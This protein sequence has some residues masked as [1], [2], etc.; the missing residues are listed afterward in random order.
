MRYVPC[1]SET[2][3]FAPGELAPE[4]VCIQYVDP[5]DG[6][7]KIVTV[8][9][10]AVATLRR[11]LTDPTVTLVLH[12]GAYDCA[13]WCRAGLTREV[14]AAFEAGR[15]LCTWVFER[16]GEVSGQTTRKQLDLA[17]CCKAHGI[18]LD[19]A[20]KQSGLG[21]EFGQ[22]RDALEIPEPHRS[23]ALGDVVVGKLFER[24]CKRFGRD[25]PLAAV[26]RLSYRQFCLQLL[27]VWGMQTD[28]DAVAALS[29]DAEAAL[30]ELRPLAQEWGFLRPNGTRNMAAIR[31]VVEESY[32]AACPRTATGLAQ[33]GEVVLEAADDP[34]LQAFSEY[35]SWLKTVSNDVPN[36]RASGT[37]WV[38]TRYGLAETLRTTSSGDKKGKRTGLIAMQNLRQAAGVRECIRPSAGH[39]FYNVDAKGL[40]L[41]TFADLCVSELGRRGM[42]DYI[43]QAGDPGIVHSRV[44]AMLA[45][46]SVETFQARLKAK[47]PLATTIRTRAKNGVFGYLG[48][49]G[50]K[51]YVEYIAKLSKGKVKL[52]V[53]EA[54][55]IR[56]AIFAAMPDIQAYLQW[57]GS[58]GLPDG[59]FDATLEYGITRRGIWY[60]AAANNRFQSR[61]AAAMGEVVI[62]L[63]KA[64]YIGGLSPARPCLFVHDELL[65][66]VPERDV[67]EFELAFLKLASAATQRIVRHVP[68][69]WDGEACDRYSK[70][71]KRVV[72]NGRLTVWSPN[73]LAA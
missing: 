60:S 59:T 24:Q 32:G 51:T 34:R 11:L 5:A 36:L 56:Q 55:E 67:H 52:T 44:G 66:E 68:I 63:C 13:V 18:Q 3:R 35:G 31:A 22:F 6:V 39:A 26:A 49:M 72:T 14:F 48:G 73:P 61:A 43:A 17:T 64:C 58:T 2:E 30:A 28:G 10:G 1:D 70:S 33:T 41:C 23:Y 25:V 27:S 4:L 69:M 57:V 7:A 40:E 15:I 19:E 38:S 46:E 42:A 37:G 9:G 47:E 54:T 29:A 16:L 53:A 62:D 21:L 71:A 12:N 20:L 8:R 50:P 45:K 65:V